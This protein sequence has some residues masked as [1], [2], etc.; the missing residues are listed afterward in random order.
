MSKRVLFVCLGNICR[1][2]AGEGVFQHF[3]RAAGSEAEIVVDSAGTAGY[4]IGK[5][6][7]QRMR[8]AAAQRGYRLDS[9]A[10]Q[11]TAGDLTAFDLVIAMDRANR[12]DLESLV[13]GAD[14]SVIK[15]LSDFLPVA[16][17]WPEEVPDP[18]YG[19]EDGFEQVL[20][21]IE[22]ACPAIHAFLRE[23]D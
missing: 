19:G 23:R 15:Q 6:A 11:V 10:R 3:V 14:H 21:M 2:P 22:A 8:A 12:S 18:Y 5:A 13:A 20:D 9:R 17:R 7:D 1:S 4:H 16:E